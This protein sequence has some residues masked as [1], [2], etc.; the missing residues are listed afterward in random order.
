MFKV[1]MT[2]TRRAKMS[3]PLMM[4]G[5]KAR[6]ILDIDGE[7]VDITH[8]LSDAKP[9]VLGGHNWPKDEGGWYLTVRSLSRE[10]DI[11]RRARE[12]ATHKRITV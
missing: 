11:E 3:E 12:R 9:S 2:G 4:F 7:D 6:L 10:V 1:A 8:L 5:H